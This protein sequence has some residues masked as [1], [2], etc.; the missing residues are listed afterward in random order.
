MD[1]GSGHIED[2]QLWCSAQWRQIAD[3][4]PTALHE[5][6]GGCTGL[7]QQHKFSVCARL[8]Q[9]RGQPAF[10]RCDCFQEVLGIVRARQVQWNPLELTKVHSSGEKWD[11]TAL[12]K[13]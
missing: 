12:V 6:Q 1:L 10:C 11:A 13:E 2:S 5:R 4:A 8:Q 9:K 7:E 3:V